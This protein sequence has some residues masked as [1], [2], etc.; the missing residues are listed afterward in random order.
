MKPERDKSPPIA[1][2]NGLWLAHTGYGPVHVLSSSLPLPGGY[3][4]G[5][6]LG[7]LAGD[8]WVARAIP[9][10][11][12]LVAFATSFARALAGEYVSVPASW[13]GRLRVR[14]PITD[15]VT[16]LEP[17]HNSSHS[18]E[19]FQQAAVSL[20]PELGDEATEGP[21][22]GP[23]SATNGHDGLTRPGSEA[24]VADC[25]SS[26]CQIRRQCTRSLCMR[27]TSPGLRAGI[28]RLVG[29]QEDADNE[30]LIAAVATLHRH[31]GE[32]TARCQRTLDNLEEALAFA[33][34][35]RDRWRAKAKRL[36]AKPGKKPR[37]KGRR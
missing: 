16:E 33:E 7:D 27:P 6:P 26:E 12:K 22:I 5:R 32:V 37:A 10:S 29:V 15:D 1:S 8:L 2:M 35:S 23:V 9:S 3:V 19:W 25:P 36:A 30:A 14:M 4:D 11:L 24:D 31:L 21:T 18:I 20:R 28:A 13:R 17:V 34:R